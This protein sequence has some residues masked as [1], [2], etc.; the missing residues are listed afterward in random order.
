MKGSVTPI[1]LTANRQRSRYETVESIR[2]KP[3]DVQVA[4]PRGARAGQRRAGAR[5]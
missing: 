2:A 1:L 3:Y 5:V 4:R